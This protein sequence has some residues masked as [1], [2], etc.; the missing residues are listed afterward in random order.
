MRPPVTLQESCS[1]LKSA[2]YKMGECCQ[3]TFYRAS[4]GC[5]G[6]LALRSSGRAT[7]KLT[8]NMPPLDSTSL[9]ILL[10]VLPRNFLMFECLVHDRQDACLRLKFF[11]REL[12]WLTDCHT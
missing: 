7:L 1:G 6:R 10:L 8:A 12:S 4:K 3:V 5:T 9:H 11:L 2:W